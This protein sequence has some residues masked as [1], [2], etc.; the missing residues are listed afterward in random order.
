MRNVLLNATLGLS[1]VAGI[2]SIASQASAQLSGDLGLSYA[3]PETTDPN[4][5][6][7]TICAGVAAGNMA[8]GTEFVTWTCNA[9]VDNGYTGAKDQAL[10]LDTSDYIEAGGFFYYSIRD[11]K[12]HSKCMGVSGGSHFL[13]NYNSRMWLGVTIP[14]G[15]GG[16]GIGDTLIQTD[17]ADQMGSAT[18]GYPVPIPWC[19]YTVSP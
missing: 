6:P 19:P 5:A 2:T 10:F 14:S 7:Y 12:N 16:V 13:Y 18:G 3:I 17:D 1:V 11:S 8:N 4:E 9:N 15:Y